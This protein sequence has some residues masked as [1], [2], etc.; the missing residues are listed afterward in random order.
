MRDEPRQES[1][2][3]L[4]L[5]GGC[6]G[7]SLASRL[8]QQIPGRR[9]A[10]IEPRQ[11][12]SEDRTW[13]GWRLEAHPFE[14][15]AVA[16]WHRWRLRTSLGVIDRG[17]TRY[18]YQM[19]RSDL[20]Y[21]KACTTIASSTGVTL[22][23]GMSATSVIETA[24]Q[25][26]VETECGNTFS[27]PY[28]VD[29][30]PPQAVPRRPWLSQNFV[31]YVVTIEDPAA[32]SFSDAPILMDFQPAGKCTAQFMYVIPMADRRF[33]CE[34]TQFAGEPETFS[35]I[36]ARLEQWLNSHASRWSCERRESGSLPMALMPK[37]SSR[38]IISAGMRG[39]SMRASTGYAFH[40]IQRWADRCANAI[41]ATAMPVG[42]QRSSLLDM[43]DALFLQ[44]LHQ[45][46]TSA[47]KIFGTLFQSAPPDALV[48]FLA[49]RPESSDLWPVVRDLPW[50]RFVGALPRGA[51]TWLAS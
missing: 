47:E 2:D 23:R 42:P 20:F 21:R 15:C 32:D 43:M 36:E 28:V 30:R 1:V 8:A 9:I 13:C 31:G 16:E 41:A 10:V 17:S 37:A 29:T 33:L 6:A 26:L 4:I 25:V 50:S 7:L 38:R 51:F 49:G 12:Y 40:A 39:G 27:A 18:P 22:H 44:V 35:Q 5:G 24:D 48:R 45:R 34:W 19:I 3:L 46:T 11:Q 14:D